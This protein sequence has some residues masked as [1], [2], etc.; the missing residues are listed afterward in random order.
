MPFAGPFG[1]PLFGQDGETGGVAVQW[2]AL[3]SPATRRLLFLEKR[4]KLLSEACHDEGGFMRAVTVVTIAVSAGCA[5]FVGSIP[6]AHSQSP[7]ESVS[8]EQIL[9]PRAGEKPSFDCAKAKTAAAQLICADGEL[10]RLDGELGAAF[11]RRK[12]QISASDQSR[13]VADQL[14]WIKDRNTR[15]DLDGKNSAAIEVLTNSK[16]CMMKAIRERIT[17]LAQTETTAPPAPPRPGQPTAPT[18]PASSRSSEGAPC[19]SILDKQSRIS[20]FE[21]A[22]IPV[23]DCNLPRDA[24]EAA[25]CRQTPGTRGS[26]PAYGFGM[27]ICMI[28][29]HHKWVENG[30]IT[31]GPPAIPDT[32][33]VGPDGQ[34]QRLSREQ[35]QQENEK[36][37]SAE[38]EAY[39]RSM[40]DAQRAGQEAQRKQAAIAA[41][42][43]RDEEARGYK[44][45]TV[46]D[47]LLDHKVY[48]ANETKISVSGF[49][50]AQNRQNERL[51]DSYNEFMMH[52]L[53]PSAFGYV[54]AL[55]VGL[56][57]EDG[58]RTMREYFLR[59]VAGCAVTILGH[60]GQCVETNSFGRQSEDV[61]LIAEDMRPQ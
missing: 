23:I 49:Y 1:A 28:H 32:V 10:A 52:T 18:P 13:F 50:H 57:T 58:S 44:H 59:C 53:N 30:V 45:V 6:P 55:N 20:C 47:L 7:E 54:E 2:S 8:H 9:V 4:P 60:V 42:I 3:W 26:P 14:A 48:A 17:S 19:E 31:G 22:G 24:G 27:Q 46:K 41:Q 12:A 56:I 11:Q 43:V 40:A 34:P 21:Q 15:C 51:Y 25:F 37:L 29:H 16:P 38:E 61:C 35:C 5:L 39:Q 36:S 33:F